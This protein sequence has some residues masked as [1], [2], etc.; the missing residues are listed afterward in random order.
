MSKSILQDKRD[1]QCYLCM[2]LN[3]D[4]DRRTGLEEHHI[5][6]GKN[7]SL[8]EHYGLKV[9]LC[10]EHHQ[11]STESVQRNKEINQL[12]HEIG[13]KAFEE[14]YPNLNFMQI[15]GKNYLDLD[16]DQKPANPHKH[17]W[18]TTSDDSEYFGRD[19]KSIQMAAGF[20]RL[21]EDEWMEGGDPF[22]QL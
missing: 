16:D 14:R 17:Q 1:G 13:Q 15:F 5:F 10:H 21:P 20:E 18:P 8:S 2:L 19:D 7:R 11:S 4:E 6:G 22:K 3:N 12:M 9:Y